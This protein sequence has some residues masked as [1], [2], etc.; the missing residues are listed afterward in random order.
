MFNI[1]TTSIYKTKDNRYFHLHASLN[2][3]PSQESLGLTP[4]SS[5]VTYGEALPIFVNAMSKITS[6]EMQ[7]LATNK[8]R[9]AGTICYSTEE[10]KA[11][12][13]GKANSHVGL[14]E[15]YSKPNSSQQ[16]SWWPDSSSPK[17]SAE[18]PLAGLKVVDLTRIIAAPAVTRG[19]AELG[20]SVMRITAEHLPDFSQLHPDLNWG[21][22][23][24][25]LDLRKEGDREKLKALVLEADV[26]V[27]GYRPGIMEK[28]GFG[29][30]DILELC[31]GRERGIIMARENCYGWHG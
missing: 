27:S 18:R 14:Y 7:I 15:I 8:F 16:A 17:T 13:H 31:K 5:P 26:V 29:P 11:S 30:E 19:L 25:F 3:K 12:E 2:A 24:A 22:W 1:L 21:K 9:Q 6:E 4:P 10:Y 28:Y 23:N 20:A